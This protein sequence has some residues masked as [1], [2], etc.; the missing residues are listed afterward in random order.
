MHVQSRKE[1]KSVCNNA[2]GVRRKEG[3]DEGGRGDEARLWPRRAAAVRVR[4]I[5]GNHSDLPLRWRSVVVRNISAG[6]AAHLCLSRHALLLSFTPLPRSPII[7]YS[8]DLHDICIMET[9]AIDRWC[10]VAAAAGEVMRAG[11]S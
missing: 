6:R 9:H 8:F 3:R 7:I 10:Q 5:R 1:A 4:C 11:E 2:D